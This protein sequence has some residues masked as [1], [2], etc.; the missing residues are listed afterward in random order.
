VRE[1]GRVAGSVVCATFALVVLLGTGPISTGKILAGYLLV[2]AAIALAALMRHARTGSEWE[3]ASRFDEA[4]RGRVAAPARPPELARMEREITLGSS[5]AAHLDM[6]L[7]PI[8]REAA[9][10]RLAAHHNVELARRPEAA[11]R[12]L[13]E[14]AWELLRPD[15]PESDDMSASGLPLR[16]IREVVETLERL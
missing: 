12:L 1:R 15:R 3:E 2:L 4:L 5:S 9:A 8:L 7:L 10:A 11:R 6:R 13:G 14:D 16:R